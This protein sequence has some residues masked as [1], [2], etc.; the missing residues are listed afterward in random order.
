ML[1]QEEIAWGRYVIDHRAFRI[2]LRD[3]QEIL[4]S[5]FRGVATSRLASNFELWLRMR[6]PDEAAN[7][8]S[9][10]EALAKYDEARRRVSELALE[11]CTPQSYY[12]E[13]AM[14]VSEVEQVL[15]AVFNAAA[16][17]HG[18]ATGTY[19]R[20][21]QKLHGMHVVSISIG[22]ESYDAAFTPDLVLECIDNARD[23]SRVWPCVPA[24]A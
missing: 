20:Y 8:R 14:L 7:Y 18:L 17:L 23:W 16:P 12:A 4:G 9:E 13:R 22:R 11:N 15:L 2:F 1:T 6:N 10:V 3:A 24:K 21:R 19:A 5:G